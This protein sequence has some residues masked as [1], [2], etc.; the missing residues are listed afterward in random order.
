MLSAPAR[1]LQAR[2][3]ERFRAIRAQLRCSPGRMPSMA[4]VFTLLADSESAAAAELQ[5]L[6]RALDLTPLGRPSVVLGRGRWLARAERKKAPPRR[7]N[8][9]G[10]SSV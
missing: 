8:A 6:C 1:D 5:L 4:T 7:G 2:D 3:G 9:A 10:P